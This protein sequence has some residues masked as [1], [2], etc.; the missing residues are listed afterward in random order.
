MGWLQ[1]QFPDF[2]F[3]KIAEEWISSSREK[4]ML[5]QLQDRNIER[6]NLAPLL[7]SGGLGIDA[8]GKLF[9]LLNDL[10]THQENAESLGHEIAHTFHLDL[11]QNPPKNLLS[12][13][14]AETVEKFCQAFSE[15]WLNENGRERVSLFC[16]EIE[17]AKG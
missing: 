4:S 2:P 17:Q 3:A 11:R 15:I 8:D 10:N 16:S 12:P 5:Q 9:V 6:V 14:M 13:E 7:S 1:T